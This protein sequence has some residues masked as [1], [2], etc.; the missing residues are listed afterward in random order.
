[1]PFIVPIEEAIANFP[2]FTFVQALTPSE[3]KA[4]FHVRAED[5][6]DYCLKIISPKYELDRLKRE[7]LALQRLS[8]PHVVQL[9]EYTYSSGP[10]G[11]K[12]Y[13]IEQ[14]I[15][16][17]DLSEILA[18]EKLSINEVLRLFIPLFDGLASLYSIGIVHRDL[19]P[20]NIRVS[21]DLQPTIIDFG[22]AR[23]LNMPDLTLTE[24]GARIG[25]PAYFAPEQFTGT[26]HDIDHRTDLYAGGLLLYEALTGAH[27][28]LMPGMRFEELM[29]A[30][31]SSFNY[32]EN[33]AFQEL[34]S[35][36]RLLVSKLLSKER[37]RRPISGETVSKL[38]VQVIGG[39]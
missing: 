31:I 7:I 11:E 15:P 1:M 6:N 29:E 28:Y 14:F 36:L 18:R 26:K 5:G 37:S 17:H 13:M 27:P 35:N 24:Q 32:Q 4:A 23:H 34:P 10:Q 25:T 2:Q 38:L 16:G 9:I 19:K 20:S 12:H 30:A 22:L 39:L 3:Q 21:S 8:H 33:P